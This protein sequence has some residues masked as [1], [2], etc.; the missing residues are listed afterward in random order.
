MRIEYFA[1]GN[2]ASALFMYVTTSVVVTPIAA[3][4]AAGFLFGLLHKVCKTCTAN[5]E[6]E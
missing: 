1:G 5:C 4:C 2:V 6:L 3:L